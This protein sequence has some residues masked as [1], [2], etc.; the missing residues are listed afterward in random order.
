MGSDSLNISPRALWVVCPWAAPEGTAGG[1]YTPC[2]FEKEKKIPCS[3]VRF[4]AAWPLGQQREGQGDL[5]IFS[6]ASKLDRDSDGISDNLNISSRVRWVVCPWAAPEGTAGGL[7]TP[8]R[9]ESTEKK[10]QCSNG[11]FPGA[12]WPLGRQR[13]EP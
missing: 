9:L 13:E 1:V 11:R 10:N 7:Y 12:A 8:G 4:P 3:N 2:G 6:L 5:F